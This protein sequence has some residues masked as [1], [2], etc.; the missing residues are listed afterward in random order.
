M[1]L[2]WPCTQILRPDWKELPWANPLAY[3]ALSSM[4]K[5]KSFIT[6]TPGRIIKEASGLTREFLEVCG[7]FHK[8]FTLVTKDPG[9]ISWTIQCFENAL[10]YFST[11]A[12]YE[13]KMFIKV[14]PE[15]NVIK[16]V[17]SH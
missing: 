6:L 13:L 5:E 2:L 9:K 11:A 8:H 4:M 12:S 16:H 10:A 17:F 14:T 7:Q 3:W 15:V 1:G